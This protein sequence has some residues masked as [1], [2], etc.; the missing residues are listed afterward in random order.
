MTIL[1]LTRINAEPGGLLIIMEYD[2]GAQLYDEIAIDDKPHNIEDTVHTESSLVN[3]INSIIVYG[4]QH[5]DC[6]WGC[7]ACPS[8][9]SLKITKNTTD[10]VL[11]FRPCLILRH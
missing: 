11:A 6:V 10:F 3:R 1:N 5:N 2:L 9:F 7:G 4:A 8:L